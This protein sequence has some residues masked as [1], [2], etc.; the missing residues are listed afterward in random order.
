MQDCSLQQ[1]HSGKWWC[2]KCDAKKERLLPVNA[3]RNCG[4]L[5][6]RR[7]KPPTLRQRIARRLD[8]LE[9]AGRLTR[10]RDEIEARLNFC[11]QDC[12]DF[13]LLQRD[14]CPMFESLATIKPAC[15]Q[16]TRIFKRW[17][18]GLADRRWHCHRWDD[19][20]LEDQIKQ[21]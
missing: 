1:L 20:P 6:G 5:A 9:A 4:A 15:R 12:E 13:G 16:S 10:P 14:L 19:H 2:P 11:L 3:R 7:R 8:L 21:I 17:V 18:R